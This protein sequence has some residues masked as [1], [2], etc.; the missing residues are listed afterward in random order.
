MCRRR[1]L[2]AGRRGWAACFR[3]PEAAFSGNI[4]SH[5]PPNLRG[6]ALKSKPEV[7][8]MQGAEFWVL[9]NVTEQ[10]DFGCRE[11]PFWAILGASNPLF[12]RELALI[13]KPEVRLKKWAQSS[14]C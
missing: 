8:L 4:S 2:G 10:P 11:R 12:S 14:G 7:R 13:S 5:Y 9:N 1:I 3:A 6:L